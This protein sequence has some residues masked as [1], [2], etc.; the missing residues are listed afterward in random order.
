MG[1]YY[2][3]AFV[4]RTF[5]DDCHNKP[6]A[7]YVLYKSVTGDKITLRMAVSLGVGYEPFFKGR[8]PYLLHDL[9]FCFSFIKKLS[10]LFRKSFHHNLSCSIS[11]C[12]S[13]FIPSAGSMPSRRHTK[14]AI[15]RLLTVWSVKSPFLT[16]SD[17][18]YK[19]TVL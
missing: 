11:M 18:M 3:C 16:L 9:K 14:G 6:L 15:S 8:R 10:V 17:T 19:G 13:F 7:L 12:I 5:S 1:R 4:Y 2:L